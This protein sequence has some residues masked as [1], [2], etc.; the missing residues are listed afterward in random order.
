MKI[1]ALAWVLAKRPGSRPLLLF[2]G[3]SKAGDTNGQGVKAFGAAWLAHSPTG[4]AITAQAAGFERVLGILGLTDDN[5]ETGAARV[6]TA[7]YPVVLGRSTAESCSHGR[8][9]IRCRG[10]DP[11]RPAGRA[12]RI[13]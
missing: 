5:G 4:N 9:S 2:A 12:R 6:H 3:D 7:T 8:R 13:G 11:A 10:P 1:T